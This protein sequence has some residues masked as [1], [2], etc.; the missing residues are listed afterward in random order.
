MGIAEKIKEI[1]YE[2]E[3]NVPYTE[4][5]KFIYIGIEDSEGKV[6]YRHD[7]TD[8]VSSIK[9]KFKS[10]TK[11]TRWIYWPVDVNGQWTNKITNNI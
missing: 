1:E 9:V 10:Y 4:N 3:L 11:P 8:Y 5:F 2:Y 6:L 7:I